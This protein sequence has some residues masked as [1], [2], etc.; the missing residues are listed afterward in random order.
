M[1]S[2]LKDKL[3]ALKEYLRQLDT[4]VVAFS[5]GVDSTLVADVAY[6]VLGHKAVAFTVDSPT[7]GDGETAE[8]KAFAK[9]IGIRHY[10][11]YMKELDNDEFVQNDENRCYVCKFNR[12]SALVTWAKAHHIQ[13]VL[14]GSNADD[15]LDYRPGMKVLEELDHIKSPLLELGFT[16]EDVRVLAN[17]RG[18]AAWNKP[19][20]PC[21]ATRIP[22]GHIIT[23]EALERIG[24]GEAFLK[25]QGFH[26]CRVRDH[27]PIGRIEV[28][29]D[30]FS[31]FAE[32]D[33]R[34]AVQEYF[35]TLGYEY[36]C[37]DLKAFKSGNLNRHLNKE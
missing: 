18:L 33:I 24:K 4:V 35:E 2:K 1:E 21:L 16:K 9:S 27:V 14:D 23:K 6:E 34:L 17:E 7:S 8:A 29:G 26:N 36:I 37:V 28:G 11:Q 22:Y 20:A 32:D 13:W 15:L 31:R 5:G 30:E 25:Q 3:E 12:F 10:V 19:S